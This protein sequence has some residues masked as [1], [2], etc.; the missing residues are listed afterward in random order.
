MALDCPCYCTAR[1]FRHF[2]G[3]T[4]NVM[5]VDLSAGGVKSY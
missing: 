4:S 3:R 2:S 5:F 1:P